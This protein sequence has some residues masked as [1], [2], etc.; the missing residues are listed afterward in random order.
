VPY[1]YGSTDTVIYSGNLYD[2]EFIFV[3]PYALAL[4]DYKDTIASFMVLEGTAP[5]GPL[6]V[7]ISEGDSLKV[8]DITINLIDV[9]KVGVNVNIKGPVGYKI[10]RSQY[11]FVIKEIKN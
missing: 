7:Y 9:S 3:G 4:T 1:A 5:V 6:G 2:N 11:E 10:G 8:D